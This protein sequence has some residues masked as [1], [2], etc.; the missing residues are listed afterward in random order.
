MT[1]IF[2]DL[3]IRFLDDAAHAAPVVGMRVRIDHGRDRKALADVLL[4][5]LPRRAN[6]FRGHQRV[7]HDPAGLAPDEGDVGEVETAD[8]VD[9]WDHLVE[10]VVVVQYGLAE[11][12][13]MNAVEFLLFFQELKPLHVP[14]DVAGVRHDLEIF[15]GSNESFLLLLEISLVG[16]RQR[17]LCLLEHI[18]REFRG[19]FALG[20]EMSLQRGWF[21]S[22]CGALIQDQMTG[23]GE[24]RK[25]LHELSSGCHRIQ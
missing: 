4:E 1:G 7:K 9:A 12:R 13:G 18:Q 25:G 16:K 17:R 11:Q 2:P 22:A 8:L 6:H 14:G 19:R 10:P 21:L 23:Y 3:H 15:H 5:Q 24:S 20:M